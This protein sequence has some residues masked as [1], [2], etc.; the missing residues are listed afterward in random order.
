[1]CAKGFGEIT[2]I[3]GTINACGYTRI[4]AEKMTLCCQKLG[5]KGILHNPTHTDKN[6]EKSKNYLAW[7][8]ASL[9]SNRRTLGYLKNTARVTL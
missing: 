1:M 6:T 2:F 3:D 7:Y 9:E 5:R 4:V 8:A